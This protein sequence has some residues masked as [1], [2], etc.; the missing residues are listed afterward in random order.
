MTQTD[1]SSTSVAT[2]LGVVLDSRR[3]V[4]AR[5]LVVFPRTPNTALKR[6]AIDA[7]AAVE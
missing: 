3:T 4:D 2:E 5:Q 1:V 6:C 7:Q